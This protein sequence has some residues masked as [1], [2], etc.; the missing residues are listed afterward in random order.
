MSARQARLFIE[1]AHHDD[2]FR[3]RVL[4]LHDVEERMALIQ[5]E[6]FDCTAE[7]ISG[8]L[9]RLGDAHLE[10]VRG[11]LLRPPQYGAGGEAVCGIYGTS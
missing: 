1:R 11:G 5:R 8:L 10:S 9:D 6:G 4:A 7:E 3:A 2:A